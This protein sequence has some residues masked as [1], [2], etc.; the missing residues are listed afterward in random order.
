MASN[1]ITVALFESTSQG[2]TRL[3]GRSSDPQL[4]AIVRERLA[5]EARR[6]LAQLAGSPVRA[7]KTDEHNKP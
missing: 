6:H 4:V 5:C 1:E 2:G 3:L 7:V